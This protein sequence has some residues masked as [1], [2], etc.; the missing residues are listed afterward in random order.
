MCI[1]RGKNILK[2]RLVYPT[3]NKLLRFF[4]DT[5]ILI[6]SWFLHIGMKYGGVYE[7]EFEED[8]V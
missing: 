2:N 1:S 6:S 5:M 3:N 8:D 7:F 4:G